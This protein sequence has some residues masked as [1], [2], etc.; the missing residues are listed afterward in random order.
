MSIS[1]ESTRAA[2]WA[3]QQSRT[4]ARAIYD[5]G[6]A[7][8]RLDKAQEGQRAQVRGQDAADGG[9]DVERQ[10]RIERRFVTVAVGRSF[11]IE[12]LA[13]RQTDEKTR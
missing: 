5:P 10:S 2:V 13:Q 9:D 4:M 11:S 12:R 7:A 6:A 3:S 8:H 1:S